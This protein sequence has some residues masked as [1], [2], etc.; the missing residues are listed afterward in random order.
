M[1]TRPEPGGRRSRSGPRLL[2]SMLVAL[3]FCAPAWSQVPGGHPGGPQWRQRVQRWERLP[4][5]Q[6]QDI[7]REQQRYR[8]LPPREQQRLFEQ[9][10]RQRR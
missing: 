7:L 8:Q 4:P 10:R 6:R 3:A 9:Y 5:Q 1:A 2:A